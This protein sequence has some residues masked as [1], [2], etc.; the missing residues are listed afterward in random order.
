[1]RADRHRRGSKAARRAFTLMELVVVVGVIAILVVITVPAYQRVTATG[2]STACL[3]NLRQLGAALNLYLG[4]HQMIMP[5]L[6]AGRIS[7]ED[8]V[9]VLDNTL[10]R[11]VEN[12]AIFLCPADDR[13]GRASGTSYSWNVALNGQAVSNLNFLGVINELSKV[14]IM[15]DKEGFHRHLKDQVNILYGDGHA[16]QGL[17]LSTGS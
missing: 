13:H 3:S 4:E 11:Y 2:R 12:E 16:T 5:E 7:R 1:M 14:P 17:R 10:N 6:K 15:G 9:P 8:D